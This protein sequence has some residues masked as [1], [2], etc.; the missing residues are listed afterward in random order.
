[1]G[2]DGKDVEMTKSKVHKKKEDRSEKRQKIL[3]KIKAGTSTTLISPGKEIA[4]EKD[5]KLK[6]SHMKHKRKKAKRK[7]DIMQP[8]VSMKNGLILKIRP[9]LKPETEK[10]LK[11]HSKSRTKLKHENNE[12]TP[13]QQSHGLKLKIRTEQGKGH[14][15][16]NS[17]TE[18]KVP[19][20]LVSKKNLENVHKSLS[21]LSGSVL[22]SKNIVRKYKNQKSVLESAFDNDALELENVT[23]D[24]DKLVPRV[25]NGIIIHKDRLGNYTSAEQII[26]AD[27][28]ATD[29][30]KCEAGIWKVD[31]SER[32]KT[33]K[34]RKHDVPKFAKGIWEVMP[35]P[36][37]DGTPDLLKIRLSPQKP[38]PRLETNPDILYETTKLFGMD[39]HSKTDAVL[40]EDSDTFGAS[41]ATEKDL[42]LGISSVHDS[43]IEVLSSSSCNRSNGNS[44]RSVLLDENS[45]TYYQDADSLMSFD[46]P[47][48]ESSKYEHSIC[49]KC[50]GIVME[51]NN[52]T[53]SPTKCHCDLNSPSQEFQEKAGYIYISP[54]KSPSVHKKTSPKYKLDNKTPTV[55]EN[56]M[57]FMNGHE[58]YEKPSVDKST[59]LFHDE[60]KI[61]NEKSVFDFNEDEDISVK[62]PLLDHV[63]NPRVLSKT[64]EEKKQESILLGDLQEPKEP[65]TPKKRTRN[66]LS[67]SPRRKPAKDISEKSEVMEISPGRKVGLTPSKPIIIEDES[68]I[69]KDKDVKLTSIT[70]DKLS[71]KRCLL[72]EGK[73]IEG[74]NDYG[75]H[76]KDKV[77]NE[78]SKSIIVGIAKND[79]VEEKEPAKSKQIKIKMD[80]DEKLRKSGEKL[81]A[82]GVDKGENEKATVSR[83]DEKYALKNGN[84]CVAQNSDTDI[85]N[86]HSESLDM[87]NDST[88]ER[89]NSDNV[90]EQQNPKMEDQQV[91][92]KKDKVK[93]DKMNEKSKD[94]DSK[95]NENDPLLQ[96]FD[97][98][99]QKLLEYLEAKG[100]SDEVPVLCSANNDSGVEE[101]HLYTKGCSN[102]LIKSVKSFVKEAEDVTENKGQS[103][104][105]LEDVEIQ[106][107]VESH[108]SVDLEE[109]INSREETV[110]EEGL[111]KDI[112]NNANEPHKDEIIASESD[113][114]ESTGI[115]TCLE[116]E[117]VEKCIEKETIQKSNSEDSIVDIQKSNSEDSIVDKVIEQLELESESEMNEYETNIP[118]LK[119]VVEEQK[120]PGVEKKKIKPPP[121]VLKDFDED[122][123]LQVPVPDNETDLTAALEQAGLGVKTTVVMN[124][125]EDIPE[126]SNTVTA[127]SSSSSIIKSPLD[128]FQQQFL[129]FLSHKSPDP[130]ENKTKTA[131]RTKRKA[132][133]NKKTKTEQ[134][135][136]QKLVETKKSTSSVGLIADCSSDSDFEISGPKSKKRRKSS[137]AEASKPYSDCKPEDKKCD[138]KPE[139]K[140]RE[141]TKSLTSSLKGNSKDDTDHRKTST[142]NIIIVKSPNLEDDIQ[143]ELPQPDSDSDFKP[144]TQDSEHKKKSVKKTP[145][146]PSISYSRTNSEGDSQIKNLQ[147]DSDKDFEP[148]DNDVKHMKKSVK[149]APKTSSVNRNHIDFDSND[150]DFVIS[151]SELERAGLSD[152][153]F[154]NPFEP[155]VKRLKSCRERRESIK[156]RTISYNEDDENSKDSKDDHEGLDE[157]Q[158]SEIGDRSKRSKR[159]RKSICPCC[160]GSPGMHRRESHEY[161]LDYKLP[162][163]HIQFV[164]DTIRLLE[165]KAKIHRLFLSLFPSC[166]E[167][168]TQSDINTIAFDD[169][170]DDVLSTLKS[171]IQFE[172]GSDIF[173]ESEANTS[174]EPSL[175]QAVDEN[176]QQVVGDTVQQLVD[177]TVHYESVE[178]STN[179]AFEPE[180]KSENLSCMVTDGSAVVFVPSVHL[181][182]SDDSVLGTSQMPAIDQLASSDASAT[183][184]NLLPRLPTYTE[185]NE[186]DNSKKEAVVKEQTDNKLD[187]CENGVS[188]RAEE[189]HITTGSQTF[190][191]VDNVNSE[192]SLL[193]S[194]S[195][196]NN[197]PSD[198]DNVNSEFSLLESDCQVNNVPSEPIV[199]VL[200][201]ECCVSQQNTPVITTDN[202]FVNNAETSD[203]V[204]ALMNID[205]DCSSTEPIPGNMVNEIQTV[206]SETGGVIPE[207]DCEE[208]VITIDLN[209]AKVQLCRSPTSCLKLLHLKI[210]RLIWCLLPDLQV[211]A[212][213]YESLENL[214]FLLDLIIMSNN[215]ADE[216]NSLLSKMAA[217]TLKTK[218]SIKKRTENRSNSLPTGKRGRPRKPLLRRQSELNIREMG[219]RKQ[220]KVPLKRRTKSTDK[221]VMLKKLKS[222]ETNSENKHRRVVYKSPLKHAKSS[223]V[224]KLVKAA[225]ASSRRNSTGKLVQP[226]KVTDA[227]IIGAVAKKYSL[228]KSKRAKHSESINVVTIMPVDN[229]LNVQLSDK[230]K[231]LDKARTDISGVES[232]VKTNETREIRS[233]FELEFENSIGVA[234]DLALNGKLEGSTLKGPSYA[235]RANDRGGNI[236]EKMDSHMAEKSEGNIFEIMD[237]VKTDRNNGNICENIE[238][239]EREKNEILTSPINVSL[240]SPVRTSSPEKSVGS[241]SPDMK[242]RSSDKNIFELLQ[243]T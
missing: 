185:D 127:T 41:P 75:F 95:V 211:S 14:V 120:D 166:K 162:K 206:E 19:K 147:Q 212:G 209:A 139:D 85:G 87:N 98:T 22:T 4:Q 213:V 2:I 156:Q 108:T 6:S 189:S 180:H 200:D 195:Q 204:P 171:D 114:Q 184:S 186:V 201:L 145:K 178:N 155:K 231:S 23:E 173:G 35:S 170:I 143:I 69:N 151:D 52:N 118:C 102:D 161:K 62:K 1:M 88:V 196:V 117:L 169:L 116:K 242:R 179:C 68:P 103:N 141:R 183:T 54:L 149:K 224:I 159:G 43:G 39:A 80:K 57:K 210:V 136:P 240:T 158:A 94:T 77:V 45:P 222:N 221:A 59:S 50:G 135:E 97:E 165:L 138:S 227:K 190:L 148:H 202:I 37:P 215:S 131:K 72:D 164:A 64:E 90:P 150:S 140:K 220:A 167:L 20:L 5:K 115:D 160:I 56:P 154:E 243:E 48:N 17:E 110:K 153:D 27:S 142:S 235:P 33:P 236:F 34:S 26:K 216:N 55:P 225:P 3:L 66:K 241:L 18:Q 177:E 157:T 74:I 194:D 144:H 187:M 203:V 239:V 132:S 46:S 128:L 226:S 67:R 31:T 234:K 36:R 163:N 73:E 10:V 217:S 13:V 230:H 101:I 11:K 51:Q 109:T 83:P 125:D 21:K 218:H 38:P 16:L 92:E 219:D 15:V 78:S 237:S 44:V 93:V 99:S 175:E 238:A 191:N 89:V 129:S 192:F 42:E 30:P 133:S 111:K 86:H 82:S 96:S 113:L 24:G 122:S 81:N 130:E 100:I 29:I 105:N 76:L 137:P 60:S 7:L 25:K 134:K 8:A 121:V 106:S 63:K 146:T 229:R 53:Y 107:P 233:L 126:V 70:T 223:D 40:S 58:L 174:H 205:P 199:H 12:N 214:E 188:N 47:G 198:V 71:D 152:S 197:V 32:T 232:S 228:E 84:I 65:A 119:P 176:F 9:V 124:P 28:K 61:E 104:V 49:G 193:E 91:A 208:I 112:E 123:L 172:P 182:Y 181:M 207:T 79:K 168:I